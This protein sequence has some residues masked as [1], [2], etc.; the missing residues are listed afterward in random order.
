MALADRITSGPSGAVAPAAPEYVAEGF[1]GFNLDNINVVLNGDGS[2]FDEIS[3][4]YYFSPDSDY[5]YLG[6]VSNEVGEDGTGTEMGYVLAK[7]WPI[8]E[9]PGI[10]VIQDDGGVKEPKPANCIM[11]TSY[12]EEHYLDSTDPRQ[13][14][15][16][17]PFQTHKRYKL[18]MLPAAL[19]NGGIDLVFNVEPEIGSRD[20]QVFQKINNWTNSR[21]AGF[22]IQVGT[23]VGSNF[24]AAAADGGV[25]VEN[26]SLSAPTSIWDPDQLANFSEGLFGPPDIKHDRPAGFFDATTRAGFVFAEYEG[27]AELS[28]QTD[29]LNSGAT[30]GSDYSNVP[31]GGGADGQFGA[32]LPNIWLPQGIF[33][34]DD[35]NPNTD[36]ELVAWFGYN[37]VEAGYTWMEGASEEPD[38]PG[39]AP[40]DDSVIDAWSNDLLYTQGVIDDLVNVGLN[41]IV[42]VGQLTAD[43]DQFTLRITPVESVSA[44]VPGY[45]ANAS[46]PNLSYNGPVALMISPA[47]EFE[48]GSVL[49]ARVGDAAA[50]GA[51][52][53]IDQ[54]EVTIST[55]TGLSQ[56]LFLDELGEDRGAFAAILPDEYSNVAV[57][58]TVTVSY[59]GADDVSTTAVEPQ[60]PVLFTEVSVSDFAVP[61]SLFVGQSGKVSMTVTN[62]KASE[63]AVSG[64]ATIVANGVVI[65]EQPFEALEPK[66]KIRFSTKWTAEEAG[67]VS[68]TAE[69]RLDGETEAADR[70]SATTLVAV[71]PGNQNSNNFGNR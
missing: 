22:K 28:G 48:I 14:L 21:L 10:K 57:G 37:P 29:T 62:A 3:G 55:S 11:A 2:W 46:T 1:G 27:L 40:L 26:L 4:E 70:A 7:D 13:V 5:T 32:W 17:S 6:A 61:D 63:T 38:E 42:T 51:V 69:V 54:V 12:L 9:P 30:L 66:R 31:D 20:Y 71:K 59:N 24:I 49:T 43:S 47:P 16:S 58:T 35:G 25:G 67:D 36:A 44:T 53:E 15:C 60:E 39:F 19:A 68:W 50:N 23:G 33:F 56:T 41:Y 64:T 8:G 34:D 18:A 65:M 45:V 52:E